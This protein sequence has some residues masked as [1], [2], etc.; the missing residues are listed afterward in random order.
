MNFKPLPDDMPE[1]PRVACSELTDEQRKA[2]A[3]D[4]TVCHGNPPKPESL[5]TLCWNEAMLSL[6]RI[7]KI[8]RENGEL[9]LTGTQIS[10]VHR[11]MIEM[12]VAS[13]LNSAMITAEGIDLKPWF[14][15]DEVMI[16]DLMKKAIS[17]L[18]MKANKFTQPKR[19]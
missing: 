11:V 8:C 12:Q 6:Q 1:P 5:F 14:Q 2:F 16:D 7:E 9:P 13:T 10:I 19:G 18:G 3:A 4:F 17:N 15:L